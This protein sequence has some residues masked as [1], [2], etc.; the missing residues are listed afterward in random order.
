MELVVGNKVVQKP[1]TRGWR[2]DIDDSVD[3]IDEPIIREKHKLNSRGNVIG[4]VRGNQFVVFAGR[5]NNNSVSGPRD[6]AVVARGMSDFW[7]VKKVFDL[8]GV[9]YALD[10]DP[11]VDYVH[12]LTYS[13]FSYDKLEGLLLQED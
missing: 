11:D 4:F 1:Y 2:R 3:W 9:P 13:G 6:S 12:D 10:R 5:L 7:T 8:I